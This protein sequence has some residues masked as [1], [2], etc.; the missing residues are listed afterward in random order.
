MFL[1]STTR[2]K[3][4]KRHRYFSVVENR[5]LT[6]NKVTQRQV[7]Y[8]GE[9]NDSQQT[10][11]RKSL[12]VF[13]EHRRC[14][15]Q[16]ALF[17]A[18]RPLPPDAINALQV[19]LSQMQLRRPRAFGDAWLGCWLW[20]QL[21]LDRFWEPRLNAHRGEVPWTQ[22]LQVLS[23]NRLIA[24]GSEFRLHRQWFD[25]SAL[26]A[27]LQVDFAVAAK[28]RLY[29]C[30]DLLLE[31]KDA[32]FAH[33]KQRWTDLFAAEFD[34]LL[35]DLTS[36][37][38]EG[39]CEQIPKAKHGYSRDG[40]PD[41][42]QVVIALVVTPDGLPLAYEVMPGN[43]VDST[44]LKDFLQT[45]ETRYGKAR[46]TWVMDRGI[47]T[48]ETLT[49]MRSDGVS[50]LVGTPKARLSKLEQS[51]LPLPWRQVHAGLEV[52]LLADSG[53]A[54][55]LARSAQ[56]QSKEQ[57]MRKR[58][59]RVYLQGLQ[60]LRKRKHLT[61]Q[62]LLE[63]WGV[64]KHDAGRVA[65]LVDVHLPTA[66]EAITPRTFHWRLE[67][68]KLR[69]S[70]AH[71]GQYILRTNLTDQAPE[72]LWR[73]YIQLTQVEAA[74]KSLKSDLALRPIWHQLEH[75]VEAHI[76][77]AFMAYALQATLRKR[78]ELLAPGLTP[79][80]VLESLAA[81]QMV[82]V[83]LPTQDGRVLVLPRYTQPEAEQQLLLDRLKLDLPAQ[84]PPRIGPWP[85]QVAGDKAG[86]DKAERERTAPAESRDL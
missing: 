17:P 5:R 22:V 73:K 78:L 56:R 20:Q 70:A 18:D 66:D 16:L 49:Q 14:Y 43:T 2:T 55:V 61:L 19:D 52:K 64:L 50:Y 24:P 51:F 83:V 80:A 44:T 84:P 29:R 21:E 45:I 53:E 82:D 41:C 57:A 76:F 48:E 26:D 12:E 39:L 65:R 11:W 8:L 13:D 71:E 68:A 31:H 33:L 37:Y 85:T 28:D 79:R 15:D 7:L 35:Y 27:L 72:E 59:L 54:W 40:R 62:I 74:F 32:L 75:R 4:G 38:F 67:G 46:R 1:R 60:A 6:T 81:I 23:I 36:T 25:H 30:L 9:I 63:R 77:V 42:R 34:V 47:P 58:R 86:G 10:A 3:N 69:Q